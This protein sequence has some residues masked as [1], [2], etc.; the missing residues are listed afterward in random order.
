MDFLEPYREK[1]RAVPRR[2]VF[3]EGADPR[4]LAAARRLLDDGIADVILLGAPDGIHRQAGQS[5]IDTAGFTLE[6]PAGSRRVED[7][8]ERYLSLRPRTRPGVAARLLAKPLYFGASMVKAGDADLMVAGIG[9]PTGRVIEAARACIGL[10]EN[11]TT[12]SGLFLMLFPD[13]EPLIF[14]DCAVNVDPDPEALASIAI[15]AA[16]N[17]PHLLNAPARVALLSFSTQG[18]A[19]HPRVAKVRR[20]LQIAR[21]KAPELTVDG[22]MQADSALVPEIATDKMPGAGAVAGR[23]NVLIFPDLD[24]ANIG[25]KLVQ[26]L[27][28]ARAIGPILDG[29]ACPVADLS[30]GAAAEDILATSIIALAAMN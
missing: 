15:A 28:H 27:A 25:Y 29:F 10:R 22:E 1:A 8:A 19:S 7:Y 11:A 23:A 21:E 18:S 17:A 30:R 24:A 16:R 20:A 26:H 14:A 9:H 6:N 3:P 2:I 13:R 4:V 12:V 5:G